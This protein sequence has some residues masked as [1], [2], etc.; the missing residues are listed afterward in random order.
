ATASN[1]TSGAAASISATASRQQ[2]PSPVGRRPATLTMSKT[3]DPESH[4]PCA[5]WPI[6]GEAKTA[7]HDRRCVHNGREQQGGSRVTAVISDR[8]TALQMLESTSDLIE[9]VCARTDLIARDIA[10]RRLG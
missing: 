9:S 7:G 3:L 10:S 4:V 6:R 2:R 5:E 8:D 1:R